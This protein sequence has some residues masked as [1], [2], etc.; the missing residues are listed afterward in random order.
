[1]L[2]IYADPINGA[3]NAASSDL[4]LIND[5][6]YNTL[7]FI[8]DNSTETAIITSWWDFGHH[9]K[10]IAERPVT[11][12]GTTQTDQAAHWV[13]RMFMTD[14]EAEAVGIL[15][16]LDCSHS[17]AF[18]TLMELTN[19]DSHKSLKIVREIILLDKEK[20][21]KKL[22]EYNISAEKIDEIIPYTHCNPPE[23]YAIASEDMIGKSGVWSHFG[24]WNFE[25]A[26]IWYNARNLPQRRSCKVH[27]RSFWIYKRKS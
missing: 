11:F 22:K 18:N 14:N 12:D 7:T 19:K 9:F 6:W 15:R 21:R 3:I 17:K 27:S 26:D 8:K 25:R 23:G 16:M 10:A 24:S 20:A 2:F 5:A 1:M 13:G 4:P